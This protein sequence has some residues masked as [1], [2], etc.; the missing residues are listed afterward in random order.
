[1]FDDIAGKFFPIFLNDN[2]VLSEVAFAGRY[3]FDLKHKFCRL[4]QI[5]GFLGGGL[6]GFLLAFTTALPQGL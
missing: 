5:Q 3:E 1:M 2:S 6:L 4:Y